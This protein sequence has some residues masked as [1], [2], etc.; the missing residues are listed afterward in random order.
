[1]GL[2]YFSVSIRLGHRSQRNDRINEDGL[3]KKKGVTAIENR[4]KALTVVEHLTELRK[5]LIIVILSFVLFFIAGFYFAPDILFMIKESSKTTNIEW[6]VF[7]FTDGVMIY[8]KCA[9]IFSILF[10]LPVFF[11]QTWRF[12]RPALT[13]QEAKSTFWFVPVSFMLFLI[14]ASFAYFVLFPMLLQFMST[15]NQSIGAVETYGMDKYLTFLFN[16]VFPVAVVFELPLIIL[17][18]T[19]LGIL[20]PERLKKMRKIAY[21]VLIFIAL[22]ITPP[23]FISDFLV[24]VPLILLYEISIFISRWVARKEKKI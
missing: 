9:F 14:G 10:T 18:L 3:F 6:N 12:V 21:F 11:Y 5:R 4:E 16:I 23:D 1:M 24:S 22:V 19:K 15:I 20:S 7:G 13:P 8:L 2:R 17:F